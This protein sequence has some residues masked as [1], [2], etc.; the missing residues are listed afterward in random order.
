M[1]LTEKMK[2]VEARVVI[3][4]FCKKDIPTKE[5]HDDLGMSLLTR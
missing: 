2:E 4:Y 5:I 3:E 1:Y